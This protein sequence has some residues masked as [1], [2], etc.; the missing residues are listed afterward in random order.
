MRYLQLFMLLLVIGFNVAYFVY[1]TET[2]SYGMLLVLLFLAE[3]DDTV[4]RFK[5][6]NGK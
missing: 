1:N 5:E 3:L 2:I 6:D 4:T